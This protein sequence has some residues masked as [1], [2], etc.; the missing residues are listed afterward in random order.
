VLAAISGL[1]GCY[2]GWKALR[3]AKAA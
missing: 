2:L 1:A 3:A